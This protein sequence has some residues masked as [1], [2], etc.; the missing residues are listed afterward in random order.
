MTREFRFQEAL[1]TIANFPPPQRQLVCQLAIEY[2]GSP[3]A[4]AK[5]AYLAELPEGHHRVFVARQRLAYALVHL[6][7]TGKIDEWATMKRIETKKE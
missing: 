4:V 1:E 6:I 2:F 5:M 7:L 3:R